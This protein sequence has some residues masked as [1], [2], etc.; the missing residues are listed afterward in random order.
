MDAAGG[1]VRGHVGIDTHLDL[2]AARRSRRG[3]KDE[4]LAYLVIRGVSERRQSLRR[5]SRQGALL[6]RFISF[7]T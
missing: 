2:L 4:S 6:I 5:R 7:N 1:V 3:G